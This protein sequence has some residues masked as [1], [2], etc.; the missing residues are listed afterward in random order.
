MTVTTPNVTRNK[1]PEWGAQSERIAM[2]NVEEFVRLE[3]LALTGREATEE[4][5]AEC[6]RY[7]ED[8]SL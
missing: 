2:D 7:I 6:V 3:F 1:R 8:S 5:V 4:E